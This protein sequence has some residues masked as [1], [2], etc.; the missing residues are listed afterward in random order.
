MVRVED[1]D[2]SVGM[3]N[4]IYQFPCRRMSAIVVASVTRIFVGDGR[5]GLVREEGDTIS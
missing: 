5:V 3:S 2:G 1:S 4:V